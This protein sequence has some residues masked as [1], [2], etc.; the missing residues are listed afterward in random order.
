MM[1]RAIIMA[2]LISGMG[3]PAHATEWINCASADNAAEFSILVGAMDVI[4]ISG[5][6]MAAGET[7][8]SSA[9][10]YG[11]GAPIAVGQAYEDAETIRV[12]AMD[13][14]L[15]RRIG[16]LRLFKATEGDELTVFSGTLRIPGHGAWAVACSGP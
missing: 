16:E 9:Q 1:R 2:A 11:P 5:I 8:W 12:D 15:E 4:A 13:E 6:T 3:L 14:N 7:R 10:A